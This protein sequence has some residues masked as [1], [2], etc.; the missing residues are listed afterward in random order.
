MGTQGGAFQPF[1]THLGETWARR[2]G[3]AGCPLSRPAPGAPRTWWTREA[4]GTKPRTRGHLH[5]V[6]IP[7]G[8]GGRFWPQPA[9]RVSQAEPARRPSPLPRGKALPRC[10]AAWPLPSLFVLRQQ[11]SL[12]Q[13]LWNEPRRSRRERSAAGGGGEGCRVE[14]EVK[15]L[16]SCLLSLGPPP[17]RPAL[18]RAR[19]CNPLPAESSHPALPPSAF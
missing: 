6:Q 11:P 3:V 17:L 9:S 13:A 4:S 16:P 7:A 12:S 10:T 8:G 1:G 5:R 18:A 15:R 2:A 14:G 19:R